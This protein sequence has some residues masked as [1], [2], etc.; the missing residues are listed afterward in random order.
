MTPELATYDEREFYPFQMQRGALMPLLAMGHSS[1]SDATNQK[2]CGK[3]SGT[4]TF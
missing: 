3:N 4:T 2:H 1:G